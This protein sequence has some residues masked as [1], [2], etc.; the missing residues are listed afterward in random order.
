MAMDTHSLPQHKQCPDCA[1]QVLAAA[2]RCRYCGYRF[3]DGGNA[4]SPNLGRFRRRLKRDSRFAT[5]AQM[6]ATW[7][8]SISAPEK[9]AFFCLADVDDQIGYL[10]VTSERFVFFSRISRR[11]HRLLLE[12]PLSELA[13]VRVRGGHLRRHLEVQ[14]SDRRYLIR[15]LTAMELERVA[16]FLLRTSNAEAE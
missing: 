10:L 6:L 12:H 15:G 16:A 3:D 11:E 1:E 4:H 2:L 14:G 5:L 8:V 7:G 13:E 9:I